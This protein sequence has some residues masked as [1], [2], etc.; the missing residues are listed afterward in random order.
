MLIDV[1]MYLG[2]YPFRK[3]Q[4]QT[5]PELVRLMDEYE[6]DMACVSSISG[7]YYR[8]VMQGNYELLDE[9]AD[10]KDRFIPMCTINPVYA[11]AKEDL[12]TCITKLGF[13]GIRLF[14]KQHGYRL[15]CPEAVAILKAA[16]E[17]KVPVQLPIYLEDPRQRHP[18]DYIDPLNEEEI[19]KAAL[20]AEA[21]DIM[22]TNFYHQ[23]YAPDLANIRSKRSGSI[24]YDIGR[25]DCLTQDSFADVLNSC[26]I[27]NMYF[28]SGAPLQYIDVQLVKL[29]FLPQTLHITQEQIE[30]IKSRNAIKLFHLTV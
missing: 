8:D 14:P 3:T 2:H 4:N 30:T 18:M 23:L 6:I 22:L 5:A 7:I 15:D 9:I 25:I 1:N 19:E 16:A 26:G 27:E 29:A 21:T 12:E 24:C 10:Y 20:E 17:Y 11:C 28:G 13:K